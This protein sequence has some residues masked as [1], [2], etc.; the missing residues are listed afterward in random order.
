MAIP[1]KTVRE[2]WAWA[3]GRCECKRW[4]H[5]HRDRCDARLTLEAC[6]ETGVGGGWR[7]RYRVPLERGGS[8]RAENLEI[9]C[10]G[11]YRAVMGDEAKA[12]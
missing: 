7:W 4:G 3:A 10:A 6:G 11:C 5:A 8:E 12:A 9:L 1:D 2:A